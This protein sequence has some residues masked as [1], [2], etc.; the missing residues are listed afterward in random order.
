MGSSFSQRILGI[1]VI[2]L[3]HGR[4]DPLR[5][6][7]RTLLLIAGSCHRWLGTGISVDCTT[8]SSGP[9]RFG[10]GTS[11]SSEG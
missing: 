3:V 1:R 4:L 11:G 10:W 5:S 7:L 9:S 2:S 8:R 6:A